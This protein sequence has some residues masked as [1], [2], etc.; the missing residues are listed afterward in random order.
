MM[1]I[2]PSC[3][4]SGSIII[5]SIKL[6]FFL[7]NVVIISILLLSIPSTLLSPP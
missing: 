6:S 5:N 7:Y 2:Y 4:S 1:H 3:Y